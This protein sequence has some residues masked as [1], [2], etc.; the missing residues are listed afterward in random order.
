M[1]HISNPVTFR[2]RNF[3]HP[4][5]RERKQLSCERIDDHIRKDLNHQT[6]CFGMDHP[7]LQFTNSAEN[8][9]LRELRQI[10]RRL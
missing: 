9:C 1:V 10:V 4:S 7:G 6:T 5:F 2:F 3:G 8:H